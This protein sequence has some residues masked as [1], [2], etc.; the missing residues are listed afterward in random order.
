MNGPL[1]GEE[2]LGACFVIDEVEVI[3]KKAC[4]ILNSFLDGT[5]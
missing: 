1:V 2:M 5:F 4:H 3:D